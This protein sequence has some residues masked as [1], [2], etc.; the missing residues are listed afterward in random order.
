MHHKYASFVRFINLTYDIFVLNIALLIIFLKFGKITSISSLFL[1]RPII[2]MWFNINFSWVAASFFGNV[3]SLRNLI[4]F[5]EGTKKSIKGFTLMILFLVA[6]D[7]F[8]SSHSILS[9]D[10]ILEFIVLFGFFFWGARFL[11]YLL[12]KTFNL[13]MYTGKR[14]LLIG[15]N[16]AVETIKGIF[17]D[18]K[19]YGFLYGGYCDD[20]DFYPNKDL[21]KEA[22]YNRI[23]EQSIQEVFFVKT[24]IINN[25]LYELI[26]ELDK[27]T[28]RV[29]IIPDFFKF[30][31]KPQN[32]TFIGNMPLFSLREEPLQSL[33]NRMTKRGFD[34]SVSIVAIVLVFSW[35]FPLLS[36]LI[37]LESKGPIFFKQLRSGRDNRQFWCYKFRSMRINNDSDKIQAT[38]NDAR[39]TRIGNIIRKTS[40]DELPQFLNVLLGNMSV[41]GP[42]PHMLKHTEQYSELV[43]K[44]MI[45]HFVKPGITGWAQVNGYRGEISNVN[46]IAKRVEHDIWYIEHWSLLLDVQ[47]VLLTVYNIIR[48]EENA[49]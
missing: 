49:H 44:Y 8:A 47:V 24:R 41:V 23:N 20:L 21:Y 1:Y 6:L 7:F 3:Y 15:N 11:F 5:K 38:R 29:R 26:Q 4:Y 48:G 2:L 36:L 32:L 16:E 13:E 43:D 37:K 42:R 31:T 35:L 40:I 9:R 17:Y 46:D 28:I 34:V 19:E 10:I 22:L 45:R 12:K 30:Y 14:V 25:D 18:K 33:L 27:R 39:V